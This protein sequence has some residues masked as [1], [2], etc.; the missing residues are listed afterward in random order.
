MVECQLPK[1]D[2][3]GSSPVSRSF[4][5]LSFPETFSFL[6]GLFLIFIVLLLTACFHSEPGPVTHNSEY[7]Y[8]RGLQFLKEAQWELAEIEFKYSLE[9][10]NSLAPAH[11]GLAMLNLKKE[12]FFAAE[13]HANKALHLRPNWLEAI[14]LKGKIFYGKNDY[15]AALRLFQ[16]AEMIIGQNMPRNA[17]RLRNE[18]QLWSG[19]CLKNSGQMEKAQSHLNS[20]LRTD[21]RNTEALIA[22]H[23]IEVYLKSTISQSQDFGH[24][25][26]KAQ[27][28]RMDWAILIHLEL[29]PVL[30]LKSSTRDQSYN[31]KTIIDLPAEP[32]IIEAIQ[33]T[34][35]YRMLFV[36]PDQTIKPFNNLQRAEVVIAFWELWS[37]YLEPYSRVKINPRKTAPFSDLPTLHPLYEP[38]QLARR[39]G[40]LDI[41]E[42]DTIRLHGPVSGLEALLILNRIKAYLDGSEVL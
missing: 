30:R 6:K 13:F 9:L 16:K 5:F 29:L 17:N 11:L 20:V 7:H 33:N 27:L 4:F 8:Q 37:R 41:D 24:I 3:A 21:P 36:Y 10:D 23:E 25:A 38:A 19:L 1:L 12:E 42:K 2:V 14:L 35:H 31:M 15:T 28:N 26:L 34:L 18:I 22:I 40:I 39:T 32:F